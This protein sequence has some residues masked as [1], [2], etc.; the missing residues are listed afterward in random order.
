MAASQRQGS[1]DRRRLIALGIQPE[2]RVAL[3]SSTRY[4]WVLVD[5]AVMCAGG[6]T[7]TVYPTTNADDVAYIIAD[8]DSR[9]RASLAIGSDG[10]SA[11][12]C[13]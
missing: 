13:K 6:A 3:A 12:D 7:T 8:S 11:K 2:D 4:E 5:Y 10:S 9:G 1:P